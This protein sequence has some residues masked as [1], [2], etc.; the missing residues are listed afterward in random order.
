MREP[1]QEDPRTYRVVVNGEDQYSIWPADRDMPH[2]WRDTRYIGKK[3][4]CLEYIKQ[5]WT[6]MRPKS[7]RETTKAMQ[8]H[9][10]AELK[11]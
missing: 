2:G 1:D 4:Q 6:D 9:R 5:I 8:Q 3:T 7:L 11:V 10:P